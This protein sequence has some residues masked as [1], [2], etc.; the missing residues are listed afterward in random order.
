MDFLTECENKV[1]KQSFKKQQ[2]QRTNNKEI[3]YRNKIL[4]FTTTAHAPCVH[5]PS[6]L[7]DVSFSHICFPLDNPLLYHISTFNFVFNHV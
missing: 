1:T 6:D 5:N 4:A 2:T 3:F 7:M